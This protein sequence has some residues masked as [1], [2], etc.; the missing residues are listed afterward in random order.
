MSV[1]P[2][3]ASLQ[4]VQLGL[5]G[6]SISKCGDK[7]Y[8]PSFFTRLDHPAVANFIGAPVNAM[9]EISM[10]ENG[11]SHYYL[12]WQGVIYIIL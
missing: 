6:G 10:K 9:N 1:L 4:Y 11:K 8:I 12:H 2:F 3:V 7:E 5:I